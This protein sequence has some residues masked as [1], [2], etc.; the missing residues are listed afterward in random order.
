MLEEAYALINGVRLLL[1]GSGAKKAYIC[2][3]DNKPKAA[4][5]LTHILDAAKAKGLIAT[6]ETIELTVLP[7]KYPDVYKRQVSFPAQPSEPPHV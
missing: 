1:K 2:L 5:H 6:D 3:E 4:E 7:A